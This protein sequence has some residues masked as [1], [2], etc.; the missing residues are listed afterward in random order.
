MNYALISK[1]DIVKKILQEIPTEINPFLNKNIEKLIFDWWFT[2]N[3]SG[4][5]LTDLGHKAFTMS[6]IEYYHFDLKMNKPMN[7][8]LLAL[9]KK[10]KCPYYI[11]ADRKIKIYDDKIAV[12]INLYGGVFQYID[13]LR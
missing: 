8:G 13:S 1:E 5:R 11:S 10:L 7:L 12:M 9:S 4:L 6:N 3:N 2:S